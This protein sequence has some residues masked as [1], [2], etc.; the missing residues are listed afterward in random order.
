LLVAPS[1]G[2][3]LEVPLVLATGLGA[4]GCAALLAV[5]EGLRPVT[6]SGRPSPHPGLGRWGRIGGVVLVAVA[7]GAV[8][9]FRRRG[10][11]VDA[12]AVDPL[13]VLLPVIVPLAVVYVTRWTVPWLL[14]R[15]STRG[16][17]IGPGRLVGLRRVAASP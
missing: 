12:S 9:T 2:A 7:T 3:D 4:V 10:I 16:L 17:A 11:P 8:V 13:V 5:S 1:T 14:G 15:L 6:V